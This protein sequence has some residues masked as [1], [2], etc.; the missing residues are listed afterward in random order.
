MGQAKFNPKHLA[1]KRGELHPKKPGISKHQRDAILLGMVAEK[2][3]A[4]NI[5]RHLTTPPLY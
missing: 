3:G 5:M 1:A 4:T 2:T